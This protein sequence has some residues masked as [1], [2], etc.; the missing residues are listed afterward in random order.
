MSLQIRSVLVAGN[1]RKSA[2]LPS[3]V[4][5]AEVQLRK[6]DENLENWT[7]AEMLHRLIAHIERKM[8]SETPADPSYAYRWLHWARTVVTSLD[9]TSGSLDD[10]FQHYRNFEPPK[11]P[12]D[13]E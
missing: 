9:P 2:S 1:G 12:G 13:L 10:F 3:A 8:E 7:K 4:S 5:I 11:S 6:L